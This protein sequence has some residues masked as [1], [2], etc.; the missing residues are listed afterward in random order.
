MTKAEILEK[1]V[2]FQKE[3][4]QHVDP[5]EVAS[6]LLYIG[7]GIARRSRIPQ[8]TFLTVCKQ[9]YEQHGA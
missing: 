9:A 4:L 2:N 1:V 5:A 3:C 8:N 6:V 7:A